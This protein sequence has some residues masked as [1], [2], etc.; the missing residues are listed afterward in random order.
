MQRELNETY[1]SGGVGSF[2]L[3]VCCLQKPI[4]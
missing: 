1:P 3:Q 4:F 2:L